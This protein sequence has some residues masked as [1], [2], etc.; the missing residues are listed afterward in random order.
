MAM[1]QAGSFHPAA[2]IEF[3]DIEAS[4]ALEAPTHN[5]LI[6]PRLVSQ[7]TNGFWVVVFQIVEEG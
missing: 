3:N 5:P 7:P 1:F 2:V 6:V 4:E